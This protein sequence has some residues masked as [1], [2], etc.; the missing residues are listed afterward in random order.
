[1]DSAGGLRAGA[2][3]LRLALLL[4]A[5]LAPVMTPAEKAPPDI[6]A[7][8]VL[9]DPDATMLDLAAAAN[10]RLRASDPAGFALDGGHAT[11]LT[12]LQG[13]VA[14]DDLAR[15]TAAT[16]SVVSRGRPT[17]QQLTATGFYYLPWRGRALAAIRVAPTPGLVD[18]QQQ[19]ITALAPFLVADGTAA[20]FVPEP[21]G[22][23]VG[24]EIVGYVRGFVP[25]SS[26]RNY[27]PHVTVGL[28]SEAFVAGM[29]TEPFTPVRFRVSSASI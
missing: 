22:R 15:V 29:V 6:I 1:M 5:C 14:R 23:P 17:E 28:A 12:V 18:L 25:N 13:F 26:G 21:D 27:N 9:L 7:I 2:I 16:A 20:A 10:S 24:T 11:H 4:L 8:N 19:L 3:A